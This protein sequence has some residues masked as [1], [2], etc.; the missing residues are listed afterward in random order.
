[1]I[2][3]KHNVS[4]F[5]HNIFSVNPSTHWFASLYC[6]MS[7][8]LKCDSWVSFHFRCLFSVVFYQRINLRWRTK[9]CLTLFSNVGN[10]SQ[11]KITSIKVT[12]KPFWKCVPLLPC[13][14]MWPIVHSM[15]LIT[16]G[17]VTQ[18]Y[19]FLF[20][21]ATEEKKSLKRTFQQIQEEEDDDY[22]G[23]YSPQDPSA[24][25]LL[26]G[27]DPERVGNSGLKWPLVEDYGH[28]VA[29]VTT[30]M[31]SSEGTSQGPRA[32]SCPKELAGW[33][34]SLCLCVP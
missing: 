6:P 9:T 13:F 32:S 30:G 2:P 28:K 33:Q 21:L 7:F 19:H 14:Y 20:C 34:A 18:I 15:W 31:E 23:S 24:G 8:L 16:T 17:Y 29:P 4:H 1:M 25:P 22:P 5:I 3:G 11:F 12:I 26:V 10:Y 27:L